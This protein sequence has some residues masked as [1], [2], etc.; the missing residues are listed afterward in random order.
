VSNEKR[1]LVKAPEE[2][3]KWGS[4]TQPALDL[5]VVRIFI[6][7]GEVSGDLQG[8]L[9]VEALKRQAALA[10]MKLEIV[11]LGGPRMAAAGAR[12]LGDTSGIGSIGFLEAIPYILPT[13]KLRQLANQYLQQHRADLVVLIDYS[14]TNLK[15]GTYVRQYLPKVPIIYYIAPQMWVWWPNSND[16]KRIVGITDQFLA[17][18]REEARYFQ[19]RGSNV[20]WVGHPLIDLIQSA[21]SRQEARAA[22]GIAPEELTV[23]LLPASRRQELKY[24]LPVMFRSAQQI[25]SKLK[26]VKFWIPL[27][28][29]IYRQ[30][31]EEAIQRYGLQATLLSEKTQE[32]MAAADLAIAKSGTVNLELALLDVP[33]VVIYRMSPLTMW[34]ARTLRKFSIPFM[35]PPNLVLMRSIVPEFLQ[36]RATPE[37]IVPTAMKLLLDPNS[38]QQTMADYQEMRQAL[39]EVGVCDRAAREVLRMLPRD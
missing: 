2:Q 18:F 12:L 6:S 31:I 25:Q 34:A 1:E 11:A 32:V 17:I 7:T 22:L 13:L 35:S 4:H 15:I 14:G 26:Q 21:P 39:G 36:E 28:Q 20:V 16:H 30:P 10:G 8:A 24:L 9:L 19:E 5:K 37:N 38:R 23:V 3:E 29:E 27:S 33:Q